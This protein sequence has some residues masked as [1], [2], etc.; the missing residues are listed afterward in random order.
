MQDARGEAPGLDPVLTSRLLAAAEAAAASER[1]GDLFAAAPEWHEA[2]Q[3]RNFRTEFYNRLVRRLASLL[4]AA[5]AAA[6]AAAWWRQHQQ[7]LLRRRCCRRRG[8]SS[9][10]SA[11]LV[12]LSLPPRCKEH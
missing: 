8:S 7:L 11:C 9:R 4:D 2:Y 10:S 6:A 12:S 1:F 3:S 5:M